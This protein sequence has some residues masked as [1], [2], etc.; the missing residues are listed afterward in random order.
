[1]HGLDL[2]PREGEK[3]HKKPALQRNAR[4]PASAQPALQKGT[5]SQLQT[6]QKGQ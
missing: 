3:T 5:A 1:M 4:Q 6:R 2:P